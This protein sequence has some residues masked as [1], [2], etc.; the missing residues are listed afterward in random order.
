MKQEFYCKGETK[1]GCQAGTIRSKILRN[2]SLI[3]EWK[4][5]LTELRGHQY[6]C[7]SVFPLVRA[8]F[9]PRR[10]SILSQGLFSPRGHLVMSGAIFS[11]HNGVT[12]DRA[13]GMQW[14]KAKDAASHPTIPTT[15][16]YLV[17]NV[18]SAKVEKSIY[19]T[20]QNMMNCKNQ[21]ALTNICKMFQS[22]FYIPRILVC[23]V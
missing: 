12:G 18:N 16:T 13:T 6:F 3:L 9:L 19:M 22:I 1:K 4:P 11:C 15:K 2:K 20:I 7:I 23:N 8:H 10:H 14:V 17:Q 5:E 21:T